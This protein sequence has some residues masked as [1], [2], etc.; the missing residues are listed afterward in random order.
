M[1]FSAQFVAAGNQT[2]ITLKDLSEILPLRQSY[3][4]DLL[5]DDVSI[6][7]SKPI[8]IV[9]ILKIDGRK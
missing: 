5:I 8:K 1:E 2:R 4:S 7:E 9:K 6:F 3:N